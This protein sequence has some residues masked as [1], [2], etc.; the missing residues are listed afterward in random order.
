MRISAA[1]IIFTM[2]SILPSRMYVAQFLPIHDVTLIKIHKTSPPFI[3]FEELSRVS[4][5][6]DSNQFQNEILL[7]TAASGALNR[8]LFSAKVVL[9]EEVIKKEFQ[10]ISIQT[11]VSNLE[12]EISTSYIE[13]LTH[14]QKLRLQ[15]AQK[16]FQL[17]DSPTQ[18]GE[19][20][21]NHSQNNLIQIQGPLEIFGGL[22][23]TNDHHFEI[24]R[25]NE[26]VAK[27]VGTVN[28]KDGT[29]SIQVEDTQGSII[30]GLYDSS[31][32]LIGESSARVS[33]LTG[34]PNNTKHIG[35]KLNIRPQPTVGG[36]IASIQDRSTGRNKNIMKIAA[37]MFNGDETLK[38]EKDG[39][40]EAASISKGS[41]SMM[42][43]E[44]QGFVPYTKILFAGHDKNISLVPVQMNQAFLQIVLGNE[45]RGPE[46][47][48]DYSLAWGKVQVD[49]K[50]LSGVEVLLE[51]DNSAKVIYFNELYLPDE[52]LKKT[53][54]LGLFAI[55]S[56][57]EGLVS[58]VAQR[59]NSYFSHKNIILKKGVMA[60]ADIEA[61]IK[62]ESVVVRAFDAFVGSPI[63]A[64]LEMQSLPEPLELENGSAVVQLPI[65]NR[66]S[67]MM[68]QPI[69]NEYIPALYSYFDNQSYIH[70]PLIKESWLRDLRVSAHLDDSPYAGV[71]IGFVPDEDFEVFIAGAE[72]D[73]QPK[74]VY[75]NANGLQTKAQHGTIGGGFVIYNLQEGI[76]EI[77]VTGKA[78][79]KIHSRIYSV[80]KKSVTISN[81]NN[82]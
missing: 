17:E 23:V 42:D 49:G 63:K 16:N 78:T 79:G 39:A 10:K 58:I 74:L 30:A 65:L 61:S 14:Q 28:L 54:S 66:W 18:A 25:K 77:I 47:M 5:T 70:I 35:P 59:S 48:N 80:D 62:T 46:T 81:F 20:P 19:E 2:L 45:Y 60:E 82:D 7:S 4:Q 75:F 57:Q 13:E 52:S 44:S 71:A 1:K 68:V 51:N 15:L 26:G 56:S 8:P 67:L 22:A 69:S 53:S 43:I 11:E 31:G 76:H 3:A 24:R 41:T 33:T 36:N 72:T 12:N 32:K 73:D 21:A 64:E 37:R 6:D 55:L 9:N 50:N 27:E 38:V 34:A 40:F 29:Y